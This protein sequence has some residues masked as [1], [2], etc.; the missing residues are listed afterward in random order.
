MK[1]PKKGIVQKD[2]KCVVCGKDM[3]NI[4]AAKAS[5]MRKHVRDGSLKETKDEKLAN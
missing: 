4:S 3:G 2:N 1:I 5:H